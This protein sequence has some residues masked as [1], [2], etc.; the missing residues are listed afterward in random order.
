M[1]QDASGI[2]LVD[3]RLVRLG[4]AA[5]IG[6]S[7]APTTIAGA[8]LVLV[9][10]LG[11]TDR[12]L[13]FCLGMGATLLLGWIAT[14]RMLGTLTTVSDLLAAMS[15]G[16]LGIRGRIRPGY[17]PLQQLVR[18]VNR[19]GDELR[20][21]RRKRTEASRF[22]GKTLIALQDPIFVVDDQNRLRL[23]NPAGRRLIGAE[24]TS[25]VGRDLS[26][27]ALGEALEAPD[28]AVIS[29]RFPGGHGRWAIRRASWRSN[30]RDHRLIMLRD[31]SVT[32]GE[33]ERRAW[34]RLIRVLSHELNNSLGPIGSLAG[35]L[36]SLLGP[37][38]DAAEEMRLGLEAIGRRADSLGRF[39][40]GY[41]KLA[42]LPPLRPSI[43][44]L[45]LSLLRLAVLERRL[46]IVVEGTAPVTIHGDEDQLAQAFIN[47]LRNAVEAAL[48][49]GGGVRLDWS[50][51]ER[52]VCVVIEDDG[53]GLPDSD[54]LFVPFFTTKAEG[55]G[56][57]LSLV[58]LIVESHAGSVDLVPRRDGRGA[59][60]SVRL[61]LE[62]LR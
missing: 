53:P 28:N 26:S 40:S 29:G 31:L 12:L 22:L 44:R 9:D 50:A 11:W 15:E 54:A 2:A 24:R 27:L 23:I 16:D 19:L 14:N 20:D 13:I 21:G 47:L 61:P 41:G 25:V 58:R 38:L 10:N 39:L 7:L 35:S 18:D 49:L 43:F 45:D 42:R 48:P 34:Q 51:D 36:A 60:A 33:E 8:M 6:A 55:S 30:G 56:I 37:E 59:I 5:W 4:A 3:G 17:D 62:P 57:G 1:T 46:R 32:L 52:F